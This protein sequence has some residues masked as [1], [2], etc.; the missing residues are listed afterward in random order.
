MPPLALSPYHEACL[1]LPRA[2]TPTG[3]HQLFRRT[4]HP[5][6]VDVYAY[7]GLIRR[8]SVR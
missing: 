3:A 2:T 8:E 4:I 5:A 6:R 1:V 7:N